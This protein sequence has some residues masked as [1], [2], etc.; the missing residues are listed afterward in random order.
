M[1][2][3]SSSPKASKSSAL[4]L[5]RKAWRIQYVDMGK[6]RDI[7]ERAWRLAQASGDHLALG[8]AA[9]TLGNFAI[10][11]NDLERADRELGRALAHFQSPGSSRHGELLTQTANARLLWKRGHYREC[12]QQALSIRDEAL[13]LLPKDDRGILMNVIAG[14]YSALEE[15]AQAFAYLYQ[16]LR[17]SRRMRS[18][19]FD[20]VL[21]CNLSHELLEL[22]QFH[23]AFQYANDGLHRAN[24]LANPHLLGVLRVNRLICLVGLG[25]LSEA[26]E[27]LRA[28]S[29]TLLRYEG[30]LYEDFA[31]TTA[32]AA[33]QTGDIALAEAL[34]AKV[35]ATASDAMPA[36]DRFELQLAQAELARARGNPQES[37]SILRSEVLLKEEGIGSRLRCH[38]Y[39]VRAR[40]FEEIGEA[41]EALADLRRLRVEEQ[42]RS[43]RASQARYQAA[44]LQT[45]LLRMQRQRDESEARRIE[46]ERARARLQALNTRLATKIEEVRSLQQALKGELRLSEQQRKQLETARDALEAANASK[47]RFLAAASH[48]LRQPM[49]AIGLLVAALRYEDD[50]K[51]REKHLGL[52]ERSVDALEAMFAAILDLSTLESKELSPRARTLSVDG[53]LEKME[54]QFRPI[55]ERQGLTFTRRACGLMIRTDEH[56]LDRVLRNLIANAVAYTKSGGIL[57]R[58]RRRGGACQ[59][60]VWDSG[61][62]IAR[63]NRELIFEE[64][65]QVGNVQRDRDK[66]VGLGLSIAQR[67]ARLLGLRIQVRSR[68]GC[69][70]VFSLDIPLSKARQRFA[71]PAFST[72]QLGEL[73]AGLFIVLV[74]DEQPIRDASRQL[75]NSMGARCVAASSASEAI[76]EL[77][78]HLR[79]PDLLICDY[80]LET[81][82][83]G[84][85]AIL[86]IRAH[87]EEEI[88]AILLTADTQTPLREAAQ[89]YRA[90]LAHKPLT[91]VGLAQAMKTALSRGSF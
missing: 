90:V 17:V 38:F 6:S 56:L 8:W 30:N 16:A 60:E 42:G 14:A 63:K 22:G 34:L 23:E 91:A 57:I 18:N 71:H 1:R 68:P 49:H 84:L 89:A 39:Q 50:E 45:E 74:D 58:C 21:Y 33:L 59:I 20:V 47:A 10:R 41:P 9:L 7:A 43:L 44:S 85:Q 81:G 35:H 13:Q 67:A 75:L 80:R 65:F 26:A 61:I 64:F 66:G 25:Q 11:S 87:Q 52:V 83:D 55:A 40:S 15:P 54:I 78:A 36:L 37:V 46:T 76:K 28:L 69:G 79:V 72:S 2:S 70:S 77:E 51:I 27:D 24:N 88:P 29:E 53:L 73:A 12:L 4:R 3:Q 86:D 19:G 31:V 62:G 82:M 5:A 32:I 48:D